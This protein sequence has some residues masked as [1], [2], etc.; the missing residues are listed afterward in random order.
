MDKIPTQTASASIRQA[1]MVLITLRRVVR[2]MEQAGSER[3][4]RGGGN[5]DANLDDVVAAAKTMSPRW[6][7]VVRINTNVQTH[8]RKNE[9][10]T[11]RSMD[12]L[13]ELLSF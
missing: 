5:L 10:C 2:C 3:D 11:R 13:F 7:H 1:P 6:L 9:A 4:G 12:R 8:V